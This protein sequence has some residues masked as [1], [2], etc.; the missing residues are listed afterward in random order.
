[1][2]NFCMAI[3]SQFSQEPKLNFKN[4]VYRIIPPFFHKLVLGAKIKL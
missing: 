1:M 3:G 2:L 4:Y